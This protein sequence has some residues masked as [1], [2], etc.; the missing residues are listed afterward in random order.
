MCPCTSRKKIDLYTLSRSGTY[1]KKI[2]T[3][4][5]PL[6]FFWQSYPPSLALWCGGLPSSLSGSALANLRPTVV[7]SLGVCGVLVEVVLYRVHCLFTGQYW[8]FCYQ[9]F[10]NKLFLWPKKAFKHGHKVAKLRS[11]FDNT[12]FS[13]LGHQAN[14]TNIILLQL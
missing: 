3:V 4:G 9:N 5:I 12:F 1:P 7:N 6:L 2:N 8:T 10:H 14:H 11:G 13:W